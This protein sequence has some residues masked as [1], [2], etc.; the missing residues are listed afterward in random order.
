ME[1]KTIRV[2]DASGHEVEAEV[3]LNRW[4][5][6]DGFVRGA[7]ILDGLGRTTQDA[8]EA[9]FFLV[10]QLAYSEPTVYTKDY[11]PRQYVQLLP[12]SISYAGGEDATSIEWGVEE[13]AGRGRRTSTR[14]TDIPTVDVSYNRYRFPVEY[15][16]VG[17]KY[18]QHELRVSAK[19]R[20]PINTRLL[21][22]AIEGYEDHMN[23]VALIGEAESNLTGLFNS[24]LIPQANRPSGSAWSSADA[25]GIAKIL[26]DINAGINAVW[27]NTFFN[28]IPVRV[29][30]PPSVMP[31]LQAPR[32]DNSEK[33]VLQYLLANNLATSRG[34]PFDIVPGFG[35]DTA[36]SGG[37]KRAVFYSP[38]ENNMTMYIP[39]SARFLAPQLKGIWIDVPGEYRYS[40]LAVRRPKS[41]LYYDGL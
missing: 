19:N 13:R 7:R 23:D 25:T 35:L 22:A 5:T 10:N 17:Y 40:G 28:Q 6:W 16:T 18:T 9:H 38:G 20:E 21:R 36:G 8:Q 41:A 4:N 26:A 39:M 1:L 27:T 12:G 24:A 15:G 11:T 34:Q 3:D 29:V 37:T 30:V 31:V 33:T 32:S 14:G 2:M